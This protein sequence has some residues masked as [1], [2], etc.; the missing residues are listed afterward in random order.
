MSIAIFFIFKKKKKP[1]FSVLLIFSGFQDIFRCKYPSHW[2]QDSYNLS[3]T[4]IFPHLFKNY[5][6]FGYNDYQAV[7]SYTKQFLR[8]F[9]TLSRIWS[10]TLFFFLKYLNNLHPR[11]LPHTNQVI[12]VPC[13]Q[14]L[15][16]CG[17]GQWYTIGS[18]CFRTDANHFLF[19]FINHWFGFQ[20]LK[21]K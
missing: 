21:I 8:I 10:H 7:A 5:V 13:K 4:P 16:I 14:C 17:P 2:A 18:F 9:E 12:C 1:S 20:I 11:N 19:Q 3:K 6:L 15:T